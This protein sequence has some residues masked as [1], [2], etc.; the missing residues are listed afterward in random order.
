MPEVLILTLSSNALALSQRV[1]LAHAPLD[2]SFDSTG[3]I[4]MVYATYDRYLDVARLIDGKYAE[5]KQDD[6]LVDAVNR[7]D[8]LQLQDKEEGI[9]VYEIG[10]LGKMCVSNKGKKWTR[11]SEGKC[12]FLDFDDEEPKKR[13]KQ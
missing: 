7:L 9:D 13:R 3:N 6:K 10:K 8:G 4:W 5:P 1:A 12:V 11:D 2:I